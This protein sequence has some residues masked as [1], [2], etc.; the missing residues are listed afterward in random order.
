MSDGLTELAIRN[1][2]PQRKAKKLFDK[3]GSGLYLVIT[4]SGSKLWRMK[5]RF[6]G[7]ERLLALGAY[8]DVTL[9]RA[10]R[11]A[12]DARAQLADGI[13]PVEQ[14][15]AQ[16]SAAA[17]SFEIV[18]RE[19][20]KKFADRWTVGTAQTKQRRLEMHVFPRLGRRPV[21]EITASDLLGV[22]KR[23]DDAGNHDTARRV[24][25]LCGEI[26]RYAV[27][28]DRA[29]RDPSGDLRGAFAPVNTISRAAATDPEHV[30]AILQMCDAYTGY[31]VTRC[32]LR[33][34]P[35]VFVRPGELRQAEWSEIDFSRAEWTI[36]AWKMKMRNSHT[37]P[38]SL[39]A[40]TILRDVQKVTGDGRF[41]FPSGRTP[42]RPMSDNAILAAMRRMGI[43]KEEMSGH[44][45]RAVARTL[46]A[47]N[48]EALGLI[49]VIWESMGREIIEHQLAHVVRDANG[50][51]YNRTK[52]LRER[53][54]LMQAWADYLDSLKC[55]KT[56][57]HRREKS[58][59]GRSA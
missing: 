56:E 24:H 54:Q 19:W 53:R 29:E 26:L 16:R 49:G 31:A 27:A 28:T 47:E 13:D 10:R 14:R 48:L 35:L 45:W 39:Q 25:Q 12:N 34:A 58:T 23:V 32:A 8:P 5:Y 52:F 57:S 37:V 42:D 50:D 3:R 17:D 22:I 2:K 4:P 43:P 51:A 6:A 21:R 46:I 38:L 44:G 33:L 59:S 7:D 11:K 40:I 41:V 9:E 30:A 18:A 1:A 36:P 20:L 55:A 15:R